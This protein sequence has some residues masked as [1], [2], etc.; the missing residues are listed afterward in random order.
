M[1]LTI[2]M[3][4]PDSPG[5]IPFNR[6]LLLISII[7]HLQYIALAIHHSINGALTSQQAFPEMIP[8]WSCRKLDPIKIIGNI[9]MV[10]N[11]GIAEINN[12]ATY[13]VVLRVRAPH[14]M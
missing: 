14:A 5:K 8:A 9:I 11:Y 13:F 1:R 12:Y 6:S 4:K 2:I 7:L 10:F 3:T